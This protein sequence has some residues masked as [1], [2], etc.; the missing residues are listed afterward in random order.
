MR[1]SEKPRDSRACGD[2]ADAP[3]GQVTPRFW[4]TPDLPT[5]QPRD[6][7]REAQVLRPLDEVQHVAPLAAAEA[8][9]PLRVGV[10]RE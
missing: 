2:R 9:E 5:V 4:A 3:R 1:F 6:R 10:H 8:V 7:L